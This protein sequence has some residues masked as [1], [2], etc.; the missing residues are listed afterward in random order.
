M[1]KLS[2]FGIGLV[3]FVIS[4]HAS[5]MSHGEMAGIIRSANHPCAHVLELQQPAENSWKVV[6]NAGPYLVNKS[7]DGSYS[8]SALEQPESSSK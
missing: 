4:L 5:E 1:K 2:I 7:K 6:C 8:V 3:Q